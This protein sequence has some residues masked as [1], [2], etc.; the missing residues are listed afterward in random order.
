[1]RMFTKEINLKRH[2]IPPFLCFAKLT[3]NAWKCLSEAQGDLAVLKIRILLN[4][5]SLRLGHHM[6][7]GMDL[8]IFLKLGIAS[9]LSSIKQLVTIL[10]QPQSFRVNLKEEVAL[11]PQNK[12]FKALMNLSYGQEETKPMWQELAFISL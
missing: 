6:E 12:L 11:H 4:A 2:G 10:G 1:M 9:V 7:Q 8:G 3:R 5:F